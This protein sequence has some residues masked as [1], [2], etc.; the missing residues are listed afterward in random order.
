MG[1]GSPHTQLWHR[2]PVPGVNRPFAEK[3]A[4]GFQ[5]TFVVG[6]TT[7]PIPYAPAILGLAALAATFRSSI[8]PGIAVLGW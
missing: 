7:A 8:Q 1:T 6:G 5:N 4:L 3:P 2:A